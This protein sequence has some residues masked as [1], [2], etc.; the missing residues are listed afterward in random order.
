MGLVSVPRAADVVME[1]L[2]FRRKV[3]EELVRE[4]SPDICGVSISREGAPVRNYQRGIEAFQQLSVIPPRSLMQPA[5]EDLASAGPRV[6]EIVMRM[7]ESLEE[8][9]L[10]SIAIVHFRAE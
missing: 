2:L 8:A 10:V 4:G 6:N 9:L 1:G 5:F 3:S 7:Q